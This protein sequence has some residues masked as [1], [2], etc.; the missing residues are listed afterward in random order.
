MKEKD[1]EYQGCVHKARS[2]GFCLNHY[3]QVF[4]RKERGVN[5]RLKNLVVIGDEING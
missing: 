3:D 1:C 5:G 4:F 2:R